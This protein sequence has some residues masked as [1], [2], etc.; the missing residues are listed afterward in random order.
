M[1]S[2]VTRLLF[3]QHRS[4]CRHQHTQVE[5]KEAVHVKALVPVRVQCLLNHARRLGLLA[6]NG[7]NRKRVGEAKHIALV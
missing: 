5:R 7:R 2:S 4:A 3:R 6:S 1:L